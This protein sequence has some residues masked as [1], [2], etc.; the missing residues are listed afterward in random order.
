[1]I[2]PFPAYGTPLTERELEI[3]DSLS[4]GKTNIEI[5][6][7]LYLT[8]NTVKT[9]LQRIFRKLGACGRAHA[10]SIAYSQRLLAFQLLIP[11]CQGSRQVCVC[12]CHQKRRR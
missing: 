11:P 1:M 12:A 6:Q 2:V 8:T 9:H 7:E 4:R 10:V 5:G 3:L